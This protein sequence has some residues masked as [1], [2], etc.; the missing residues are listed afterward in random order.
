LGAYSGI[1]FGA[2]VVVVVVPFSMET[3]CLFQKALLW[4]A[5]GNYDR[6]G[7]T[8]VSAAVELDVRWENRN[9]DILDPFGNTVSVDAV[10]VVNRDIAVGSIMWQGGTADVPGTSGIPQAG[11]LYVAMYEKI[12]DIKN[13][14]SRRRVFL[15]RSTDT[16]PEIG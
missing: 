16:L 12:P 11:F 2:P 10:V 5:T 9:Q 3:D 4:G 1:A 13:Q 14:Y 8:K 15:V 7:N 6:K